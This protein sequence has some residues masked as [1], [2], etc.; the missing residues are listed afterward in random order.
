MSAPLG[1]GDQSARRASG[2]E[3]GAWQFIFAEFGA[4]LGEEFTEVF[5]GPGYTA[6]YRAYV[7]AEF[8]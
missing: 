7:D 5:P 4:N 1:G 8:V 6:F 3:P 2:F